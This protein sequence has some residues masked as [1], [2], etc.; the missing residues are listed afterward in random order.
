MGTTATTITA[1]VQTYQGS[2]NPERG[3]SPVNPHESAPEVDK[4]FKDLK[5]LMKTVFICYKNT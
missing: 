3:T 5:D 4:D 2:H 1:Q